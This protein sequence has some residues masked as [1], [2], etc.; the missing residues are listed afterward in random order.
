VVIVACGDKA[1][2]VMRCGQHS[3]PID[4][5]IAL[6]HMA[7]QAVREG[8][9][10]CWIGSFF[11]DQVRQL[12]GIPEHIA[13]IEVLPLGYPAD[14]AGAKKRVSMAEIACYDRWG[15]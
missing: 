10:T 12:L 11:A 3:A 1:D 4:V 14:Q 9:A 6:E 7:L 13:I 8:L 15:F 2:H 5:A